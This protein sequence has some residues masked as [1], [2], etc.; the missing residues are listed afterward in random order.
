M[1]PLSPLPIKDTT[2]TRIHLVRQLLITLETHEAKMWYPNEEV[3]R[4]FQQRNNTYRLELEA[5]LA[6]LLVK[7]NT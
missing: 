2:A 6:E 3:L 5:E 4:I 7:R 1:S